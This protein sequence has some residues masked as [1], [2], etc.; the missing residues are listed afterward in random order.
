MGTGRV[1]GRSAIVTGGAQGMGEP[2]DVAQAVLFLV[3]DEA[4][5]MTGAELAVDGGSIL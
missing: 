2:R 3:S 5:Y 1:E 4:R